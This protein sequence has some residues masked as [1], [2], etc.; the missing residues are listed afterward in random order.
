MSRKNAPRSAP[1]EGAKPTYHDVETSDQSN[2][3]D[4]S[5]SESEDS[6]EPQKKRSRLPSNCPHCSGSFKD[7][8]DSI[9]LLVATLTG[10]YY[11]KLT[12]VV[13][14]AF[15]ALPLLS[16]YE[17]VRE[18]LAAVDLLAQARNPK[19]YDEYLLIGTDLR[20]PQRDIM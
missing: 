5:K 3:V 12:T 11:T 2:D 8:M 18:V 19:D 14:R 10:Q 1:L 6:D 16:R 9:D 17:I 4:C 13:F 20:N 15:Q 7:D